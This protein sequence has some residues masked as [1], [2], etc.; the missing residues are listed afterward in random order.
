MEV[1]KGNIKVLIHF[2]NKQ[3]DAYNP[4]LLDGLKNAW[5]ILVAPRYSSGANF[6]FKPVSGWQSIE[7]AEADLVEKGTGKN[8][9]LFYLR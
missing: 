2:P 3:A 9:M 6:E 7:F 1:I 8:F 4:V 5:D